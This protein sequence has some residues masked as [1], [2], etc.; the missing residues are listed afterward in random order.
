MASVNDP[1]KKAFSELAADVV[2]TVAMENA[3]TGKRTSKV[4]R[5]TPLS[6]KGAPNPVVQVVSPRDP[7]EIVKSVL[8]TFKRKR[9]EMSTDPN[10]RITDYELSQLARFTDKFNLIPYAKLLHYVPRLVNVVTVSLS[11]RPCLI[12]INYTHVKVSV[13]QLAEAIPVEGSGIKLPLDLRV[14]AS[15]CKNAYYAP[16]KFSAVQIAFSEPRCRV[17]VFRECTRFKHAR[18]VIY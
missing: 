4:A 17:L 14:I 18:F 8:E 12:M 11:V 10:T 6:K 15:K 5:A 1:F 2:S 13:S 3:L 7:V 9:K 16:K